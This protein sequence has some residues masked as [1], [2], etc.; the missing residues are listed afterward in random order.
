MPG[1]FPLHARPL[2]LLF[3]IPGTLGPNRLLTCC[4]TAFR[5]L[6]KVH[7]IPEYASPLT[8]CPLTL[9]C[10]SFSTYHPLTCHIL[11]LIFNL[12]TGRVCPLECKLYKSRDLFCSFIFYSQ[13][14]DHYRCS[15][16]EMLIIDDK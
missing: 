8:P 14:L 7:Y 6:L 4:L 10:L 2:Y 15:I 13:C 16:I 9:I 11:N 3:L 12:L 5:S 1:V